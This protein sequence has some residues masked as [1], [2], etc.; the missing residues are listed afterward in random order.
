MHDMHG[1]VNFNFEENQ[2]WNFST[3]FFQLLDPTREIS[4]ETIFTTTGTSYS[5][6]DDQWTKASSIGFAAT[7]STLQTPAS[8]TSEVF[9]PTDA[10]TGR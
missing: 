2:L 7:N 10:S 6:G 9:R 4:H 5:C 1:D 3:F 8:S